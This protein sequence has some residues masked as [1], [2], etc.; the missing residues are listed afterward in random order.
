MDRISVMLADR[1]GI[2]EHVVSEALSFIGYNRADFFT[3]TTKSTLPALVLG[4]RLTPLTELASILKEKLG[5]ILLRDMT[6]ILVAIFLEPRSTDMCFE[7]L[8]GVLISSTS[9]EARAEMEPARLT[10]SCIVPLIVA[11][12]VE[13]GDDDP[14]TSKNAVHALRKA[15]AVQTNRNLEKD[16]D[17]GP[18]LRPHMLGVIAGLNDILHDIRGKKTVAHKR[19]II[20]SLTVIIHLIGGAMSSF[21]P[22]VGF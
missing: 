14:K 16:V 1:L 13:V 22:Q 8:S 9:G 3:T 20:R 18:F 19:K 4:R 7:F 5:V 12:V 15:Y 6:E 21:S 2:Q 17:L 10:T 11:L